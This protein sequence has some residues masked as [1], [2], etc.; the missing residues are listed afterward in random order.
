MTRAVLS[1]FADEYKTAFDGQIEGL[2]SFGID[3]IE[4]RFVDGKN[5]ATL[6]DEEVASVKKRLCE[7]NIR[8]SAIG[9]PLG[10]IKTTDD[11]DAEMKKAER[12]FSIANELGTKNIRMFSFFLPYEKRAEYREEV[13]AR[14][15]KMVKE[16]EKH[17]ITL[18]H[19]NEAAIYGQMPCEVS[20]ILTN[21]PG[22]GGI[23]DPANYRMAG[24]DV[25]EGIEATFK[26]FKYMHVKDAI[27]KE[28]MIVP[29]GEGEGEIAKI[30]NII[31]ERASGVVYLTLEPHLHIFDAYK[32]I[33]EHE[34]RGKY[35]FNTNE[36]AFSFA[37]TA[38]KNLLLENGYL[39]SEEK[40]WTR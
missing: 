3:F 27:Y 20:D 4:L 11:I 15:S 6:S 8:V 25:F 7:S 38:L 30:I 10:K 23:F 40:I 9:S 2:K 13:I 17:G 14:L 31:D 33:D 18:C 21:V 36:E 26:N 37:S 32:S 5:V 39:E 19:E 34:L 16:A 22:L 1:A 28:Q 35:K 12:V 29:A 24:A